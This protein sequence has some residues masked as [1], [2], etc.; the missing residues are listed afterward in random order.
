MRKHTTEP[1]ATQHPPPVHE[2]EAL[3]Y[4]KKRQALEDWR[5]V[6]QHIYSKG[7]ACTGG[8]VTATTATGLNAAV[9][10]A[11]INI[12][13]LTD[14]KLELILQSFVAEEWDVLFIIDTQL[15]KKGGDYM[16]K[17][18][19]RRL[20][21]G[22]RTHA[23]PCILDYGTDT[24]T[25]FRRAGGILAVIGPKWGTSLGAIQDDKFGPDRA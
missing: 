24:T 10:V 6:D 5:Q 16:G 9:T 19:K 18:I 2:A 1:P 22:T 23:S 15:D 4:D 12:R 25:G 13:G 8:T 3:Y 11:S 17:K 7:D 14:V 20:G 21:T